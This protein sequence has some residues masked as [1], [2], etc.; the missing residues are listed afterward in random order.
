MA[1]NVVSLVV[2]FSW[3]GRLI[4]KHTI[5]ALSAKLSIPTIKYGFCVNHLAVCLPWSDAS[6]RGGGKGVQFFPSN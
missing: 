5:I 1:Q 4:H 3:R 6:G 2:N